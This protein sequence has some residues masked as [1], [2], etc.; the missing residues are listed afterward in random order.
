MMSPSHNSASKLRRNRAVE[1]FRFQVDSYELR[2]ILMDRLEV[3]ATAMQ[4]IEAL[5]SG[6][7]PRI[8]REIASMA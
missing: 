6:V 8:A 5:R 3:L 7:E 4:R 1:E 2:R